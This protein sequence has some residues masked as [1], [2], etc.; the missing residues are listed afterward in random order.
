M[1]NPLYRKD[2][3]DEEYDREWNRFMLWFGRTVAVIVATIV[4]GII[5]IAGIKVFI[6]L[7]G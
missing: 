5:I 7:W 3:E 1:S 4:L 2:D 6:I